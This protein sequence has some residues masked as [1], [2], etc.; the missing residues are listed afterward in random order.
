MKIRAILMLPIYGRNY[1][2]G[3]ER[4][5]IFHRQR[6]TQVRSVLGSIDVRLGSAGQIGVLT[7]RI[8][9]FATQTPATNE[10][11]ARPKCRIDIS[12]KDTARTKGWR[13]RP[14]APIS[15]VDVPA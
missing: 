12:K 3:V 4:S 14:G 10:K 13:L 6:K 1:Q 9:R 15:R 11:S 5:I 2:Y 8:K 7:E